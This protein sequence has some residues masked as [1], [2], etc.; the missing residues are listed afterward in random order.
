MEHLTLSRDM[1][2]I[3][4]LWWVMAGDEEQHPRSPRSRKNRQNMLWDDVRR[5]LVSTDFTH[6]CVRD[7]NGMVPPVAM[8]ACKVEFQ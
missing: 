6:F 8:R 2:M 7:A 3:G 4:G 1:V 5:V